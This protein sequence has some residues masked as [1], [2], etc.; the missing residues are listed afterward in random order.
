MY[1]NLKPSSVNNAAVQRISRQGE[2]AANFYQASWPIG[3]SGWTSGD[4]SVVIDGLDNGWNENSIPTSLGYTGGIPAM[5]QNTLFQIGGSE[6]LPL[7]C[8]SSTANS[9]RA[10]AQQMSHGMQ[11]VIPVTKSASGLC[12][13]AVRRVKV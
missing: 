2:D 5:V 13:R 11:V 7:V 10:W 12:A 6:C 1:R 8:W 3:I 9:S 4:Y